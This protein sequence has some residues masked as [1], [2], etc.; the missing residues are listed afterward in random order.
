MA[1]NAQ[2]GRTSDPRDR[3]GAK[4]FSHRSQTAHGA[5]HIEPDAQMTYLVAFPDVDAATRT[6]IAP[7]SAVP[8]ARCPSR[9]NRLRRCGPKTARNNNVAR[10]N[11]EETQNQLDA[12][13]SPVASRYGEA[14]E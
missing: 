13:S 1:A 9:L 12:G 10:L 11:R 3:R 6:S 8:T 4:G 14:L 7:N 2:C 5:V